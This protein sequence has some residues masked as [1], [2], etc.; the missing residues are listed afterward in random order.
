MSRPRI[1]K[2]ICILVLLCSFQCHPQA[3][4]SFSPTVYNHLINAGLP[5]RL[6]SKNSAWQFRI[7]GLIPESQRSPG[8]GKWQSSP[9]LLS[10]VSH[11]QRSLVDYSPWDHKESDMTEQL[12]FHFYALQK[13]MAAHS[14]V[15]AWRIPGMGEP[16][17]LPF[18]GSH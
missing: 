11:G 1:L 8:G 18:I 12:H 17:G 7:C 15:L 13:E 4:A 5:W 6:S 10:G 3:T 14:S 2:L 16:G 9:V